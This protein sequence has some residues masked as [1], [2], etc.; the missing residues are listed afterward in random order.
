VAGEGEDNPTLYTLERDHN[1][2]QKTVGD[3]WII[4]GSATVPYIVF[5]SY[6]KTR[7]R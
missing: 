7:L 3:A 5:P 2:V 6:I 4:L 1:L